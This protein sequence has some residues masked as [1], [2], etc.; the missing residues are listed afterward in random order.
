[1]PEL[2]ILIVLRTTVGTLRPLYKPGGHHDEEAD[3]HYDEVLRD[4]SAAERDDRSDDQGESLR[5]HAL[6]YTRPLGMVLAG[7]VERLLP[8]RLTDATVFTGEVLLVDSYSECISNADTPEE[9][10]ACN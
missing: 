7:S 6:H 4:R 8:V 5:L 10:N 3:E 1:M 2:T 9:M